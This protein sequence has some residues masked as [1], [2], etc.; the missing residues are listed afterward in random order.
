MI[1]TRNHVKWS[2]R[3][4]YLVKEKLVKQVKK[5][6]YCFGIKDAELVEKKK[7]T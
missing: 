4:I 1:D 3:N 6:D 5:T 7:I 2:M